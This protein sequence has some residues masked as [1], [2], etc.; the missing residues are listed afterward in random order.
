MS[1]AL[2]MRGLLSMAEPDFD[3]A[4]VGAGLVGS[5][6]AMGLAEAGRRT[7]LLDAGEDT[8]HASGGNFGLVWVQGKG[9]GASPY[10]VWTRRSTDGWP[11]F[12]ASLQD[13]T[14][15]DVSYV[16]TGGL[17]LCLDEAE[18]E[19]R[20]TIVKRMHNQPAPGASET[21][22]LDGTAL[23][24]LVPAVGPTVAGA[25][26]CPHDGHVNPLLLLRAL[27]LAFTRAS[28]VVRR[29]AA[30]ERI[31]AT[32]GFRLATAAGTI[33]AERLVLAA[34]HGNAALAPL[35]GL[36]AP[37]RPQR[38]QILV[39]ERV[40]ELCPYACHHFRQT[41][42]G[43]VMLGDTKED[44]GFDRS[45]TQEAAAALAR[46]A[47]T[48]FPV[49]AST[50]VVR[51]WAALRVL[52]PDGLPIYAQSRHHPGAFLATCHSGVTLAAAHAGPFAQALA[53]GGLPDGLDSF[54]PDRFPR[55]A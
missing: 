12:A 55:A 34:G 52:S 5:A 33:V 37:V 43:T 11:E 41:A 26:F 35:V 42:D 8:L 50:R 32:D 20:A 27:Q 54:G 49:L 23:R 22:A 14:G 36:D 30:V 24:R 48:S 40:P 10:A 25:T 29:G 9:A 4:V 45:T 51:Q 18:L 3:F 31:Q 17:S 38:G 28:G 53:S 21:E 16:R 1:P 19:A 6:I 46:R 15:I 44:V 13:A 7:V 2:P 47:V 39:T